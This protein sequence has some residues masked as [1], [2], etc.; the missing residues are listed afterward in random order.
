MAATKPDGL[1]P[2]PLLRQQNVCS[3]GL[4]SMNMVFH[5]YGLNLPERELEKNH[6]VRRE[7]LQR[8]GFGPGRLGRIALT[9]GYKVELIEPDDAE[10]GARFEKEGGRWLR[11]APAKADIEGCLASGVP[12]VAC[13]P[14]KSKAFENCSHRGSHWVTVTGH[15][16]GEFAIHDPAP[17]RKAVRCK[18]GY[19]ESW[20][21]SLI[22]ISKSA[23]LL[24]F[25]RH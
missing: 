18:P 7:F 14:D 15:R 20:G 5:F 13:I 12:T 3:C 23:E 17:W 6:L 8:H 21:C 1:L 16:D 24:S 10:V 25:L 2:V 19:W 11:R 22:A 9:Y 4:A